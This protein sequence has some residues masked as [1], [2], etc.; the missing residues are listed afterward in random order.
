ME[1]TFSHVFCLFV[2]KIPLKIQL[3]G[4]VERV[5]IICEKAIFTTLSNG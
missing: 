2:W 4:V 1:K 5:Y 3:Q